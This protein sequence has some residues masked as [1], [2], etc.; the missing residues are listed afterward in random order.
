MKI[1]IKFKDLLVFLYKLV[2]EKYE[3]LV[4]LFVL[5]FKILGVLLV[6]K[7]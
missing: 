1:D 4:F 2:L 7:Y 3:L 6:L 5:V